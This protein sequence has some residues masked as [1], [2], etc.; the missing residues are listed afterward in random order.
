M[1]QV[2]N[3]S[4]TS[5]PADADLKAFNNDFLKKYT[6]SASH[7]QSAF[8]IRFILD[9]SSKSQNEADLKKT[10]DLSGITI[11]QATAGL[12]L[13]DEWK[14]EQTVKDDYRAKA[15]SRWSEA[16]VFSQ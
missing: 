1:A 10:L 9:S 4:F 5:P 15:A 12:A 16:T 3:E 2:L 14:S 6:D 8:N 11:E 13:L 7:L